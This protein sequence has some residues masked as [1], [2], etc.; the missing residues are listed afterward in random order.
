MPSLADIV[1]TVDDIAA[2][3][4]I[5]SRS[6]LSL[7]TN[8]VPA[9]WTHITKVDPEEGKDLPLLFPLYL[10]HTSATEVGGSRD[11]TGEN[12]ADTFELVADRPRPAFQEPSAARHVTERTREMAAFLAIPEVVN[13]D[14]EAMVGTLG[15]GIEHMKT[16]L[17]P[18]ML[19][20]KLPVSLGSFEDRLADVAASWMLRNAIFESYIIM[21]LDSAAAREGNVTEERLLDPVQARRRAM[22]VEHYLESEVVYLEYSGRF[23]GREAAELLEAIDD[24]VS[25]PR[26]WYGGGLDN[27]ENAQAMLDA[28]AD[29][30]VVGNVFHRIAAE[31]SEHCDAIA[32]TLG[33]DAGESAVEGWVEDHVE[34]PE[35]SAAKYL[36]TVPDVADPEDLARRYLVATLHTYLQLQGL[37]EGLDATSAGDIEAS[38]DAS[39]PGMAHVRPVLD[40][41][42]FYRRLV[43]SLLADSLGLSPDLPVS[44]LSVDL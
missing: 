13:G 43:V 31:E 2:A 37:A 10:Q 12:T 40:D 34:V 4:R 9:A 35:S 39:V 21:N 38:L 41:G 3:A 16:D 23:G 42:S 26:I 36:S 19:E 25:W 17:G 30:V 15:E 1:R 27:R 24:A 18:K 22:A 29:A 28:G 8:P 5:G 7:D 44:H 11:V 20:D 33:P 6:V 14:A 32:A